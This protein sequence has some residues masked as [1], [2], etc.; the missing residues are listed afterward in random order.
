M[1]SLMCLAVAVFFE[2]RGETTMGQ[3]AVAEVVMNR[4]EDP[5]YPDTV[6]DVVF[7]DRQFS[8][9]HD[10]RPDRLPRLPTR[11]SLSTYS[12]SQ[13]AARKAR[14]VASD[15]LGGYRMG[16]SSTHY[17]TVSVDPFWNEHFELD[18]KIGNHLF[19]T[20]ETNYR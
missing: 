4:V 2:A 17:H 18:G 9:T 3:Y 10:G 5:R 19:Y 15:V 11:A 6:C 8:F 12:A 13:L 1:T 20:N 14:T 7:E 16:I